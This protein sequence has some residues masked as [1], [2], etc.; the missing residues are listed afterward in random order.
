[1]AYSG[2][3]PGFVR[4]TAIVFPAGGTSKRYGVK[5]KT[6]NAALG[7]SAWQIKLIKTG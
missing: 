7:V 1:V 2:A 5:M 3:A 4:S 6:D